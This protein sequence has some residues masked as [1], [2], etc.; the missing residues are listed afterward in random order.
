MGGGGMSGWGGVGWGL[1]SHGGE[2]G[3]KGFRRRGGFD[4]N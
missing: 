3:E 1:E 2:G 4:L